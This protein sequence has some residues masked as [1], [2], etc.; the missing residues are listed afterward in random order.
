MDRRCWWCAL[1]WL[2]SLLL[3]TTAAAA[4]TEPLGYPESLGDEPPASS[5]VR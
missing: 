1:G 3:A 4:Q 2:G 5:V